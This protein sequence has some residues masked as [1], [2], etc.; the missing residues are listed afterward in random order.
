[1]DHLVTPGAADARGGPGQRPRA[2]TAWNSIFAPNG[3]APELIRLTV[4]AHL[5]EALLAGASD[6]DAAIR[7]VAR[8]R[9]SLLVAKFRRA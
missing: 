7:A 4:T 1:M 5:T 9:M 6:S 2:A 8:S 3:S